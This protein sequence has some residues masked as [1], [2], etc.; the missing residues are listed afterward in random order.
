MHPYNRTS[1]NARSYRRGD[2]AGDNE[3]LANEL[4]VKVD[5]LRELSKNIGEEVKEQNAFLD[6]S[7]SDMFVRSENMLRKAFHR[8]GIIR[9]DQGF[10]GCSLYCQLFLFAF[11][12]FFLCWLIL[13]FAG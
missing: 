3:A 4:C 1:Q 12:F 2:L 10:C 9:R 13:K 8:V 11:L 7:L 5:L 6:G